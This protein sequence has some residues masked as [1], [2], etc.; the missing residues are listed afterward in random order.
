MTISL[1]ELRQRLHDPNLTI[2]DVRALASYNGWRTIGAARG[3]HI[4]GAVAFPIAWLES[5]DKPEVER[6]LQSKGILFSHEVVLYGNGPQDPVALKT[7]LAELGQAAV[8]ITRA[9]GASGP[10]TR[11]CRSIA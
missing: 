8:R 11:R 10:P 1:G 5:V 4:P 9:V 3:G 7:R 6:Q 2:V